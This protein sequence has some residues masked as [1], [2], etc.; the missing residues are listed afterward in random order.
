MQYNTPQKTIS[1]PSLHTDLMNQIEYLI[2]QSSEVVKDIQSEDL[3]IKQKKEVIEI[4]EDKEAGIENGIEALT[5]IHDILNDFELI[6]QYYVNKLQYKL[7]RVSKKLL[8]FEN[9]NQNQSKREEL[10]KEILQPSQSF[11]VFNLDDDEKAQLEIWTMKEINEV[12]FD[13]DNDDW[14]VNTSVFDQ[15]LMNKKQLVFL[16]EDE[17]NN[18]FGYYLSTQIEPNRYNHFVRTDNNTFIFSLKSNGRLNQ[19]MKFEIKDIDGGYEMK[20][21]HHNVLI[22]LGF[23]SD[24]AIHLKKF[25][26]KSESYCV[27]SDSFNWHGMENALTGKPSFGKFTPRRIVVIEMI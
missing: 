6:Q 5:Y 13:S 16:I 25:N 27:N 3:N 11:E 19:M 2:Q 1:I 10:E 4:A 22:H 8:K 21:N 14:N 15:K 23:G 20:Q 18:K 24:G 7:S 26:S 17:E 9:I 12:I